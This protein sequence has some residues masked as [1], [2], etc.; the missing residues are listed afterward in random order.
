M[1]SIIKW[2]VFSSP[3]FF[4]FCCKS[5]TTHIDLNMKT[6]NALQCHKVRSEQR[7]EEGLVH[8]RVNLTPSRGI[9]NRCRVV[10]CSRTRD[11]YFPHQETRKRWIIAVKRDKWKPAPHSIACHAHFQP[12]DQRGGASSDG[13]VAKTYKILGSALNST[14]KTFTPYYTFLF[15]GV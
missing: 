4:K 1:I 11:A 12:E 14:D 13:G 5:L 7:L 15:H 9:L 6:K 3:C 10:G 8:G 2:D